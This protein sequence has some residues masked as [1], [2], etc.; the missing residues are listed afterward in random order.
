MA[1]DCELLEV[2][3]EQIQDP[4]NYYKGLDLPNRVIC[5]NVIVFERL[6][7][8]SLQQQDLANRMHHR[9]VL[10]RVLKTGGVV[11][12]DGQSFKLEA[13][14]ALLVT[15]YQFHHYVD[16]ELDQLR[17]LFITFDL[18]QGDASLTD[19][20]YRRLQP[21][22]A[23]HR[24]WG[25]IASLW[26]HQDADRRSEIMP[27]LDRLLTHLQATATHPSRTTLP[28]QDS[29]HEWIAQVEA[30]IIRS[31]REGWTFEEVAQ[32]VGFSQRH[33]R[34]RF[35]RQMGLSL[36]DYR[37]N[38]QFHTAISLMRDSRCSLSDVAEL[39]GFNSQSVF[40]RFIRRMANR[41][42]R[43]LCRQIRAGDYEL[44]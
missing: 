31:V 43:E 4:V 28:R 2:F 15:P 5:R 6:T 16:L 17:W 21:D 19:L 8:K 23:A 42:P 1:D 44:S 18:I 29:A 37:S 3:P 14:E 36:R 41:T 39:S 32:R 34:E 20:S 40:T 12:V 35:E 30:L 9:Y 7:R 24:L 10:M 25:E 33:L 26:G 38:Y 22:G 13:G 27:V 11:S